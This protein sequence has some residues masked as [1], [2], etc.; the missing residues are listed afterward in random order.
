MPGVMATI[1]QPRK[2]LEVMLREWHNRKDR[3][4]PGV[5]SD[6]GLYLS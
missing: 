2:I 5:H 4:N 3:K 6:L 1:L